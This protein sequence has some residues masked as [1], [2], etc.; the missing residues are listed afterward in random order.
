MP[1]PAS[2]VEVCNLALSQ[3]KVSPISSISPPDEGVEA[4]AA[5]A[6]WYDT[7]RLETLRAHTWNFA[8]KRVTITPDATAP[9]FGW[10]KAY[11]LPLDY[12]RPVAVFFGD[13]ELQ[14]SEYKVED[15]KLLCNEDGTLQ[16]VHIYDHQ[17]PAAW[18]LDFTVGCATNL[19]KWVGPPLSASDGNTQLAEARS[20]KSIR[21][22]R[23]VNGQE[24]LPRR[25]EFSRIL[26][27]RLRM[28]GNIRVR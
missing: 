25:V 9:A 18:P 15:G 1:K 28:S 19:A 12:V 3:L 23:G 17:N 22:A 20:D 14:E 10:A 26:A 24:S 5:C 16:L 21:G 2:A 7:A 6:Q 4:A 27:R 8:R 13:V 11:S